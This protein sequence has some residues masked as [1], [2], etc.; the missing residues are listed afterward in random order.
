MDEPKDNAMMFTNLE[1]A[2]LAI[3]ALCLA[4]VAALCGEWERRWTMRK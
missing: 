1:L 3:V 2:V 4:V